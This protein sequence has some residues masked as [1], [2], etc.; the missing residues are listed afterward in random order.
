MTRAYWSRHLV[1]SLNTL[2][3]KDP[4]AYHLLGVQ[5][6]SPSSVPHKTIRSAKLR[7]I[8]VNLVATKVPL[9]TCAILKAP[10]V[11]LL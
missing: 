9:V 5:L 10:G 2:S 6:H 8:V 7:A 1:L 11:L 4:F 3:L